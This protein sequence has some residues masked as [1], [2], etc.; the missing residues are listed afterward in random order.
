MRLLQEMDA[1]RQFGE[2][3]VH[4]QSGKP[5]WVEGHPKTRTRVG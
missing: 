3:V 2:I 4:V 1:R 5:I